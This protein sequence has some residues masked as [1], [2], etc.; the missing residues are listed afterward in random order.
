MTR[1]SE[2]EKLNIIRKKAIYNKF[3]RKQ[4]LLW[5]NTKNRNWKNLKPNSVVIAE[6]KNNIR[7][8]VT[9]SQGIHITMPEDDKMRN[10][11]QKRPLYN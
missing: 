8:W 1:M 9:Y 4:S 7:P 5:I 11:D 2:Y 6:R 10:K 3:R